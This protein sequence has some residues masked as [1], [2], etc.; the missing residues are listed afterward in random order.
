MRQVRRSALVPYTAQAMFDLV[1]DV[2][3]YPEFLPWCSDA[4]EHERNDEQVRATL[5]LH[6][7]SMSKRFTTLN[8]REPGAS[9]TMDLVDGPFRHLEGVWHFEPVGESGSK[10]ALHIDFE[11]SSPV[12]SLMFG[13]FFEQTCSSLVDAF[14][15]RAREVYG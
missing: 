6:K 15:R 4:V 1:D 9:L 7:G 8:T 11:F 5:E 10:V 13:S 14:T 3:S 12:L 2:A